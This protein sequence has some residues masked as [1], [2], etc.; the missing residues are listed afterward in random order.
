[1]RRWPILLTL[2]L[3]APA[4]AALAQD[5]PPECPESTHR[6]A[7]GLCV[8]DDGYEWSEE[9][10]QCLMVACP[11]HSARPPGLEQNPFACQCLR[12]YTRSEDGE[13]CVTWDP[14]PAE[15]EIRDA[16]GECGCPD[17]ATSRDDP[18]TEDVVEPGCD[19]NEGW[20]FDAEFYNCVPT[21]LQCPDNAHQEQLEG[22]DVQVDGSTQRCVCD[23]GFSWQRATLGCTRVVS[24]CG[25]HSHPSESDTG[26][27]C[28]DGFHPAPPGTAGCVGQI[29]VRC[30]PNA[31]EDPE[32]G[33]CVC[34]SGY[35]LTDDER[36]ERIYQPGPAAEGEGEGAVDEG[37]ATTEPESLC[38][39]AVPGRR[40]AAST[41]ALFAALALLLRRRT[42]R[43]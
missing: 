32:T 34:N 28:D 39:V 13:L 7:E 27:V 38:A 37:Q 15:N 5:E 6:N 21:E 10:L 29:K 2:P 3:L 42:G 40:G 33:G 11:E 41:W 1:M 31:H 36:C 24:E 12:G 25:P 35:E 14:C 9:D 43:R 23:E 8:C 22:D 18:E 19:C 16:D 4:A 26:C 20:Q 17:H 30:Q